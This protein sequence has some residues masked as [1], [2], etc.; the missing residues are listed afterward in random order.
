MIRQG[1]LVFENADSMSGVMDLRFGGLSLV[2]RG[3]RTMARVG[4]KRILVIVPADAA[5]VSVS[6]ITRKL[7][8]SLEIVPWGTAAS[9]RF[10]AGEDFL[11]P[12]LVSRLGLLCLAVESNQSQQAH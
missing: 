12:L 6:R 5:P 3:I 1:I 10:P 11:Q 8:I 2:D 9:T 4:I 7:D